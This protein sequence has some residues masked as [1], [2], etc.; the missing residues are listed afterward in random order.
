MEDN[1][2]MKDVIESVTATPDSRAFTLKGT[3]DLGSTC[4]S[5]SSNEGTTTPLY[6]NVRTW[7]SNVRLMILKP[8]VKSENMTIKNIVSTFFGI[9][10]S[11]FNR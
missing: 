5:L 10:Y 9:A 11:S 7:Q 3:L 2:A 1:T 8:Y 6:N 4:I